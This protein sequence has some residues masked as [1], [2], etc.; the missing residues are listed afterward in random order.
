MSKDIDD[1]FDDSKGDPIMD[2]P[3]SKT[4][5]PYIRVTTAWLKRVL[6]LVSSAEQL[7]IVMWLF[8]RWNVCRCKEWFTVPTKELDEEL[9]LSRF[10]RYRAFKHLEQA[11]GIVVSRVGKKTMR[12]KLLW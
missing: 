8:R 3:D 10:T 2:A 1:L 5:D 6:P 11:G 9:G 4:S 7:V 12:V